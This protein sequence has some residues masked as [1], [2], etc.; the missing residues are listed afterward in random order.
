MANVLSFGRDWRLVLLS[1]F[2]A[3]FAVASLIL[4][5]LL[6]F[7][8][9]M[10]AFR[11]GLAAALLLGAAV[12][13]WTILSATRPSRESAGRMRLKLAFSNLLEFNL[14]HR[15]LLDWVAQEKPDVVV[16]AEALLS[17]RQVL[18]ELERDYPHW[19][20]SRQGD[21]RIYSRTPF[22]EEPVDLFVEIGHAVIV[23]LDGLTL[24]GVHTASPEDLRRSRA[25][26]DLLESVAQYLVCSEGPVVV[27]GDFNAVPWM[28]AV[29]RFRHRVG[30]ACGPGARIGTFPTGALGRWVPRWFTIPIDIIM[31]GRGARVMAR[32]HGP[33]I[34]SDHWPIVAEIAHAGAVNRSADRAAAT[35]SSGQKAG[36]LPSR[37]S[38]A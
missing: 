38:D 33:Q 30:L 24:A 15:K 25:L 8:D 16:L 2:R 21:V 4:A 10:P 37:R 29:R 26:D 34:G 31:A 6:A 32:R 17:W 13:F 28:R 9:A 11:L 35:G 5:A 18:P 14:Q 27:V 36:A 23:R 7:I 1:N 12:S 22:E 19:A 3:Q 20:G